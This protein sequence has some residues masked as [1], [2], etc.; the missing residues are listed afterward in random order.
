[1]TEEKEI[2]SLSPKSTKII[3]PLKNKGPYILGATLGEGA[4]AKVKVATQIHTCEKTAIKILD[5]S[6]LL[7][8]EKDVIRFKK[9]IN[10]LKRLHHKNIIQLYEIMESKKSLYIVMEYCER[11]ELFDYIV[12][13]GKIE[14]K[15]A[16]RLFQQIINGVEYLHQQN[17]IHR[18]LKP[19]NLLL[20][21]N[22]NIKISDFGL[23]T[24]Y[25]KNSYLNTP[26]GTPSYAP[27]EMLNG[28]SYNGNFSDI[29]SCGIILYAMLCG[30][31]PFN[32]SKEEIIC[33]KI[34]NHDYIIPNFLS[35]DAKNL[36]C[37]ILKINPCE[38]FTIE[39]IKRHPWFN[40]INPH[41]TPGLTIGVNKVPVDENILSMVENYGF[42]KEKCRENLINNKY[43]SVTCIYYLCLKKYIRDGNKS[44]SDLTS[45]VFEN[46][47]KE[48][49]N[50]I[51]YVNQ[52][53][54]NNMEK[55]DID[56]DKHNCDKGKSNIMEIEN[57]CTIEVT[58][59]NLGKENG[60]SNLNN[61]N[62]LSP[63]VKIVIREKPKNNYDIDYNEN[64]DNKENNGNINNNNNNCLNNEENNYID[65]NNIQ[66]NKSFINHIVQKEEE[67]NNT[68]IDLKIKEKR[69]ETPVLNHLKLQKVSGLKSQKNIIKNENKRT[70]IQKS[71][72]LEEPYKVEII[73]T[74]SKNKKKKIINASSNVNIFKVNNL[75]QQ[76]KNNF[77][78]NKF[79][80]TQS[81]PKLSN[82]NSHHY[83]K[84]SNALIKN[85]PQQR[86]KIIVQQSSSRSNYLKKPSNTNY[87]INNK[88]THFKKTNIKKKSSP[89]LPNIKITTNIKKKIKEFSHSIATPTIK[90]PNLLLLNASNK[91]SKNNSIINNKSN[92]K[93]KI[94]IKSITRD[95][96]KNET[97][98]TNIIT[99]TSSNLNNNNFHDIQNSNQK[100][101]STPSISKKVSYAFD[102]KNKTPSHRKNIDNKNY[103]SEIN[104]RKNPI[105]QKNPFIYD[106]DDDE[107]LLID[108]EK[109]INVL[110]YI[111]RR[112]VASSF[113]SSFNIQKQKLFY[114]QINI[115][116]NN[117][118]NNNNNINL[119]N[120]DSDEEIE[121]IKYYNNS[122]LNS[123]N[124][125]ENGNI[126]NSNFKSLVSIL[127]QKFKNFIH[128]NDLNFNNNINNN[129][130][131]NGI[132]N[133]NNLNNISNNNNISHKKIELKN[134][135]KRNSRIPN[136]N[137]NI[138][139]N[140]KNE[141]NIEYNINNMKNHY[142]KFLD[143]STNYDPG[144]DSRGDSSVER[145]MSLRSNDLKRFSFSPERSVYSYKEK[146]SNEIRLNSS[147]INK[148]SSSLIKLS[149]NQI[150][151][152]SEDEEYS[153]NNN[154]IKNKSNRRKSRKINYPFEKKVTI[155]L[156]MT[157]ENCTNGKYNNGIINEK[158][159]L[160]LNNN[161]KNEK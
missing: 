37:N 35:N 69:A 94:H 132:N 40:F 150:G 120:V 46:Y 20:D 160:S 136:R 87:T 77:E 50:L 7:E 142:N 80:T 158:R 49:K 34:L 100:I 95:N 41:L 17:I 74:K 83:L 116:N 156:S 32:E 68:I 47:I 111:A 113:C 1:M 62:N 127:N 85:T 16:C 123:H 76:M 28:N 44:I 25:N 97:I 24:F 147:F 101:L 27:P 112:L 30:Y 145:S 2:L 93:E 6:K 92:P 134:T 108:E 99:T 19:E 110:D 117:K 118:D 141:P 59:D 57:I 52:V 75:E 42:D 115:K 11:G 153:L 79:K 63:Q 64:N 23:S 22:K 14:E 138:S 103:K 55:V 114:N 61:N 21:S 72:Q 15:E 90:D 88:N 45:D 146:R 102:F 60:M 71:R 128:I 70:F 4:F 5:K 86:N 82:N 58:K 144:L 89:N 54:I 126:E 56:D 137:F 18:D 133:D 3:K 154:G 161:K 129:N 107:S 81:K 159:K 9:E 130:E 104:K 125:N 109:P 131:N 98:S 139:K 65:K 149:S 38:R 122:N 36:I 96:N 48:D 106:E 12:K 43:D 157:I 33:K 143:M 78:K 140:F 105:M 10:I 155:N 67:K 121:D 31:L 73:S 119:V 152:I 8:D 26:C 29:W 135:N 51:G 66:I 91:K 151:I 148:S 13:L 124:D 53:N 39:Q 84:S